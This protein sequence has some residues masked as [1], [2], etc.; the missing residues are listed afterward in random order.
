MNKQ[1]LVATF[2]AAVLAGCA[3]TQ[4]Q[5]GADP[6]DPSWITPQQA[7]MSAAEAAPAGVDGTFAMTVQATGTQNG[8][9]YLNSERDYRDQRNLTVALSP[10]AAAQLAQ[11][12]RE[13]PSAGLRGEDILVRGTARRTTIYFYANGRMTDKYYYQT[14]VDVTDADQV[15]I[16]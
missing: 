9:I 15:T 5:P 6:G 14:H 13:P 3:G 8:R 10:R 4:P 16:R 2:V 7:V 1:F 11:R 12:L